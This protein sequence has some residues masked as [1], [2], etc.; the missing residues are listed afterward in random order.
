MTSIRI[1]SNTSGTGTVT[2]AV[3]STN[4]DR[5][6][7]LPSGGGFGKVLQVKHVNLNSAIVFS[8]T[9][10]ADLTGVTLSITPSSTTSKIMCMYSSGIE[11]Y[12]VGS[13]ATLT[14]FRDA[15]SLALIIC[16]RTD[17]FGASMATLN[18][19]DSPTSTST[20]TY[21]IRAKRNAAGSH[22]VGY[23]SSNISLILMEIEP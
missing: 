17:Y 6:I 10:E 14:L 18:Y 15:T 8:G 22:S 16:D 2:I 3:P 1:A 9:T 13:F 11:N 19:V 12:T 20:L 21:K 23:L 4:S 5:T 7:T